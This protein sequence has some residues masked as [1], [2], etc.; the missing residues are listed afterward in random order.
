MLFRSGGYVA[1]A[2][3]CRKLM[4]EG[5]LREM[6]LT[7]QVAAVSAGIVD[8]VPLLDL[9]Y[10]EDSGA[11]VDLNCVM[12]REGDLVELQGTGEGRAF[13]IQEQRQLVDLCAKGIRE[14]LAIQ[15]AVLEGGAL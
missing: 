9:C 7:T 11:M 1:L 14:L 4:E 10:E 6:P 15:A 3:A 13:T 5:V 2:L 12:T 8:D